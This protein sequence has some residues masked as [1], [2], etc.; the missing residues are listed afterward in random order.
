MP[1]QR[2]STRA[3]RNRVTTPTGILVTGIRIS[4]FLENIKRQLPGQGGDAVAFVSQ[5]V[6]TILMLLYGKARPLFEEFHA[7][8]VRTAESV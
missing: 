5:Y 8:G 1:R 6:R 2:Y 7:L 4:H 3:K